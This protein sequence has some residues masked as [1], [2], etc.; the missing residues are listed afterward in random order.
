LRLQPVEVLLTEARVDAEDR[1]EA[2][3]EENRAHQEHERDSDLRGDEQ[4]LEGKLAAVR[5]GS[6]S[7]GVHA[8]ARGANRGRKAEENAR[9]SSDGGGEHEQAPIRTEVEQQ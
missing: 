6:T 1:A 3:H 9:E 8:S 5:G 7:T 2:L 4:T